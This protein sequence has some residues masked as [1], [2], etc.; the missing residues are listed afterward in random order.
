MKRED[1]ITKAWSEY[2]LIDSGDGRKLEQFASVVLDRPDPQVLWAKSSPQVWLEAQAQF[3]WA[4]KGERWKI[5]KGLPESWTMTCHNMT[6]TLSFKGFK[7][8]GIFPE[9]AHQWEEIIVLGKKNKNLR[10]LNLFGYTGAAS[11]AGALAGMEVTHVDASKSTIETVKE[12]IALSGLSKD[13]VRIICED[14]LK[15]VKRLI[16]RGEH[17]EVIVLDPPAFG[18]GPKGEVWK[19]E[20]SLR[21]LLSFIPDILSPEAKLVILNGY[22]SG[23]SARTFGELLGTVVPSGSVSYGDV[24]ILQKNSERI[25][26][27]GIYAKWRA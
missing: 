22:A 15:Y 12:N 8:I 11:V 26:S 19:I 3:L 10:M 17:F 16:Q 21:E 25:L 23:Y 18:R 9:H 14:A 13:A 6:L 2:A 4:D 7:H 5:A 20:E 1:V 24:G 27:T